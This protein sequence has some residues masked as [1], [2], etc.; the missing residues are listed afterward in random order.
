MSGLAALLAGHTKP[1]LYRWHSAAHVE[2]IAHAVDKAGWR[3]FYLD[4][5][6]VEDKESFLKAAG[7]A[8]DLPD[9]DGA[10]FDVLSD[11]LADLTADGKDGIV[12]IWDGW[13]PLGRADEQAFNIALTVFGGR[14]HAERGDK[15]AVLLRGEGPSIDVPEL[16][17]GPH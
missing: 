7:A 12:L 6:T 11:R 3:F 5:W 8:L 15:L 9:Y 14:V 4:G 10:S 1:D 2:D 16:P 13:S 17:D